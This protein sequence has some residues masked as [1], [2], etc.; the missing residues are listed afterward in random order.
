[1]EKASLKPSSAAFTTNMCGITFI[2]TD[3]DRYTASALT[4]DFACGARLA[5][6]ATLVLASNFGLRHAITIL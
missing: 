2:G 4:A 6:L 3:A 5:P 1:L